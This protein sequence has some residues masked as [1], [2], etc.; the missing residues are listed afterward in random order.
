MWHSKK[1]GHL[2]V[3]FARKPGMQ[4][5]RPVGKRTLAATCLPPC[6][7]MNSGSDGALALGMQ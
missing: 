6:R 1:D 2:A 5:I 7:K 4:N 3:L